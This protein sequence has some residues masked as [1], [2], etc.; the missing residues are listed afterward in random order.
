MDKFEKYI[1]SRKSYDTLISVFNLVCEIAEKEKS[2]DK[3]VYAC[4]LFHV[5]AKNLHEQGKISD[6]LWTQCEFLGDKAVESYITDIV[7]LW[8]KVVP[9]FKRLKRMLKK[10]KCSGNKT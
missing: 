1:A 5:I 8:N 7:G 9:I 4:Q 6:E 3:L 2:D 10:L